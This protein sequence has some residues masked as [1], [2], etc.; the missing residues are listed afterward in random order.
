M[1]SKADVTSTSPRGDR[2]SVYLPLEVVID[3][4]ADNVLLRAAL[5]KSEG[6]GIRR[7]LITQELKHRIGNLL[8]VVQAMA[9]Q[10]FG[11]AD[12]ASVE[13]FNA[14]LH[15]LSEAQK[16]LIDGET[17]PASLRAVVATALAPHA[18]D[19]ARMIMSGPELA[20]DGRRAHALTLALH[21]LA[22]N[23]AKYGALSVETGWVDISWSVSDDNLRLVWTECGGPVVQAPTRRGFGST[24][25]TRN[26]GQAFGGEVDLQFNPG[27]LTCT[28]AAPAS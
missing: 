10:T 14:R 23:A 9:R 26:L 7:E 20:L 11:D 22:T 21:E 1:Q 6:A 24:L 25:I 4:E 19:E 16:L 3:L 27:G 28:L 5:A 15:A 2:T 17:H 13:D 8:A 12:A 18:S